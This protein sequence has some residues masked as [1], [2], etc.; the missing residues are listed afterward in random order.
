M[1]SYCGRESNEPVLS[2]RFAWCVLISILSIHLLGCSALKKTREPDAA[3]VPGPASAVFRPATSPPYYLAAGDEIE[4]KFFYFDELDERL[5]IPP[6]GTISLQL[7]EDVHASGL[8]V[9]ELEELLTRAYSERLDRPELAVM[10]R[11]SASMRAYVGGEVRAPQVVSIDGAMTIMQ[12]LY[13]AGG[14][15]DSAE[16]DSVIIV[17]KAGANEST[18]IRINLDGE[19]AMNRNDIQL[20]PLDIVYVPKK[21][22]SEVGLFVKQ[23]I[24][25][26]VPKHISVGFAFTKRLDDD[27]EAT[28]QFLP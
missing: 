22:I 3:T 5:V 6:D 23:Y 16:M 9:K 7:V 19:E 2:M 13:A 28:V 24:D 25:D 18:I 15:L 1:T 8:T 26:I 27:R 4:V 17:R 11:R 10:L 14:P 12:A 21:F 20:L